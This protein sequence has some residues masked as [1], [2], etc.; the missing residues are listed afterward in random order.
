MCNDVDH[1][2][3]AWTSFLIKY[4]RGGVV[5]Y[6]ELKRS[7][8]EELDRYLRH[9]EG[10]CP[11]AAARWPL[12]QRLAYWINAYNAYAIKLV[13]THYPVRSIR[14]IGLLSGAAFRQSF[15]PLAHVAGAVGKG[16]T[17]LSLNDLEHEILRKLGDPRIHFALVCAAKGS[18]ALRPIAYRALELT[19]Q[20]DEASRL[21]VR[22]TTKNRYDS[23]DR[24]LYLSMIFK[25][26]EGDFKRAAGSVS[27]FV[28][29]YADPA[30][31]PALG[32]GEVHV[33]YLEYDWGLN[34]Q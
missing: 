8:I 7:G 31:A 13:L 14:T 24:T 2:H 25:W 27:S 34:G 20:L 17:M 1:L 28:A 30:I 9:L 26:F 11:D 29:R 6:G 18:P 33:Q 19:R 10:A 16:R 23:A 4:N 12:P 22:D 5:Q 15:I 21:F 32:K 3:A